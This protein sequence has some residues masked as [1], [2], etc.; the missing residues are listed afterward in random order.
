MVSV[1]LIK[2]IVDTLGQR[3]FK[4]PVNRDRS[5]RKFMEAVLNHVV[6]FVDIPNLQ[7]CEAAPASMTQ[8]GEAILAM[9][10]RWACLHGFPVYGVL[11]NLNEIG[12]L[13]RC[14]ALLFTDIQL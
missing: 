14:V 2:V 12:L 4:N 1:K 11:S 8:D 7:N 9:L 3:Y 5:V 13:I 6:P 10:D